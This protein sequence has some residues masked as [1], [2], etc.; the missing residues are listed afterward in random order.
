MELSVHAVFRGWPHIVTKSA[1]VVGYHT[2]VARCTGGTVC[3]NVAA[4]DYNAATVENNAAQLAI[5]QPL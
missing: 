2:A 3:R 5:M 1:A 4:V